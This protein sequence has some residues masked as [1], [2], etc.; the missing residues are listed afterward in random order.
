LVDIGVDK[1][2]DRHVLL[3]AID[4]FS[5]RTRQYTHDALK[6]E[7]QRRKHTAQQEIRWGGGACGFT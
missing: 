5:Q 6:D 2:A 1:E 3:H 4:E 7:E